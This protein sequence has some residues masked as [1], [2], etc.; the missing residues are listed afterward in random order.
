M[1]G[2]R[3]PLLAAA[4]HALEFGI[5]MGAYTGTHCRAQRVA[6][7][8]GVPHPAPA[9]AAGGMAGMLLAMRAG[10]APRNAFATVVAVAAAAGVLD[11]AGSGGRVGAEGNG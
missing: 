6:Q 7:R 9:V 8:L 11:G 10:Q 3:G 5:L 2:P 1:Y 4:R